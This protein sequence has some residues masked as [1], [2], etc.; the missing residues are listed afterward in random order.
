M[1]AEYDYDFLIVGSGFGG[2]VSAYRLTQKG[3]RVAV[4]EQ[5]RR[6]R[7]EDFPK[8]NWS[9]KK[10]LWVPYLGMFGILGIKIFK[11][12]IV[13]HGT[14]VGG[15][16]LV[17]ANTH[18]EPL[19][20]FYNDSKWSHL[21]DWRTELR[22]HY[23]E[24]RRM[25]GS[26]PAPRQ[27]EAE[28]ALK[29][30]LGEMGQAH[31]YKPATVGIF[32][33]KPGVRVPDPY[34]GGEGPE[35]VGCTYC[36]SCMVGCQFGAK[37]TLDKG[38]LYLA[39]K[40]GAVVLPES[41]VVGIEPLGPAADGADGYAVRTECT[42]SLLGGP[43]RLLKAKNVI[44]SGGVLGTVELLYRCKDE[45]LLPRLS[46]QLGSFVRT[47]SESIQGVLAPGRD[48][49]K[50]IAIAGGGMT[51]DGTH[52][53][54]Y[55]YGDRADAMS[56]LSTVHTRGGPLPRQLYFLAALIRHPI[57][58][59]RKL[60]WPFGWSRSLAGVLAMQAQDNS[61]YLRYRRKWF[62]PWKK[63]LAS[64][65]GDRERPPTYLPQ[66]HEVTERLAKR[67][68][69]EPISIAPEVLLNATSTA[70]ILGGCPMGR[71]AEE[72]VIDHEHRVFNYRGLYVIDG[73]AISANLGVNPS[74]TITALAER[75]MSHIPTKS[76]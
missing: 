71:S 18:L 55:R 57:R 6:Y 68:G 34:F 73:S 19:D 10:S 40:R 33:G 48:M 37:N 39:E 42:T 30:V 36:G 3:Y 47:N 45:G 7:T 23:A 59:L 35:R 26:V 52:V 75:A 25:L 2:S 51:P 21:A 11:D 54:I 32:F 12:L 43:R 27:F 17:Y 49:G 67:L 14:G 15:G 31:T 58:A 72:G 74:L 44:L 4:V 22:P 13:F 9:F 60:L 38:Y 69:A 5:G 50:G 16:S 20:A 8:N 70:H 62:W 24:A 76:A 56:A 61:M 65:W 64:D 29:G 46:G 28:E 66:A 53:E 41:R 63:S 1:A